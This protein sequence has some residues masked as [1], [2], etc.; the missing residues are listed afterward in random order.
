[1]PLISPSY[2]LVI[3]IWNPKNIT[4]NDILIQTLI[5]GSHLYKNWMNE[6]WTQK[7]KNNIETLVSS[8]PLHRSGS[9]NTMYKV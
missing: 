6:N 2:H 9:Q 1:M 5:I 3:H 8:N 4:F 7:I